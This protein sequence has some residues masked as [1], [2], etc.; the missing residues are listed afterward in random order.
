MSNIF[1]EYKNSNKKII[2]FAP[3]AGVSDVAYRGICASFGAHFTYTEMVSALGI[4]Y[5]PDRCT[6]LR[7]RSEKEK[8]CAIQ[9]FGDDPKIM[10]KIAKENHQKYDFVDINMGCPAPKITK[11]SQG[12]ALMKTPELASDIVKAMVDAIDKPVTVK[13]RSG[14]DANSINAVEFAKKLE[15]AGASCIAVHGRYRQQFYAGK[16]DLGVIKAVADAL[17]IPVIGNGDIF[18]AEDATNMINE[19]G[20]DGI[21]AARGAQGNP[22]IFAQ[23][24]DLLEGKAKREFSMDDRVRIILEHSR[25]LQEVFDEKMMALKMRKHLCWYTKGIRKAS[26]LKQK[27]IKVESYDDIYEY[28]QML[29]A[30]TI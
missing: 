14:W 4:H 1:S 7:M 5:N 10:A 9:L 30:I 22:F 19:T 23:I 21:M 2:A 24:T 15:Q 8:V 18:E 28:C 27:A 3:M 16:A 20:C 6:E 26:E 29:K 13:I 17:N 11:N 25:A 12:S